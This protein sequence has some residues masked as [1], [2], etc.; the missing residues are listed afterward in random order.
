MTATSAL[1]QW[2]LWYRIQLPNDIAWARAS[3]MTCCPGLTP[4]GS[5]WP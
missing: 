3:L 5:S 4:P 2:Q 1:A